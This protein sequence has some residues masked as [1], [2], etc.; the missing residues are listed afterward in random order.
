MEQRNI[1]D[2]LETQENA[3]I[4][5][6]QLEASIATLSDNIKSMSKE[7]LASKPETLAKEGVAVHLKK[8]DLDNLRDWA[9]L[10]VNNCAQLKLPEIVL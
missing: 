7:R 4:S 5:T 3:T 9:S 6:K 1:D 10:T 8:A 2:V